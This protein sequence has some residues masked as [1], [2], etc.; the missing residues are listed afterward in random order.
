MPVRNV[1]DIECSVREDVILELGL[2]LT[3]LEE[4]RC[5]RTSGTEPTSGGGNR[6]SL[7]PTLGM[8]CKQNVLC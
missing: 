3:D 8:V 1:M 4:A 6:G 2:T 5:L 7:A